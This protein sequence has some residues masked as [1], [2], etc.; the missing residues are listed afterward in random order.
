MNDAIVYVHG[1]NILT[2]GEALELVYSKLGRSCGDI[3]FDLE[4]ITTLDK[5]GDCYAQ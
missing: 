2:E 3:M 1:D 4:Y 5:L